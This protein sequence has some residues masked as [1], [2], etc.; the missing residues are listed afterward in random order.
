M[1]TYPS[2]NDYNRNLIGNKRKRVNAGVRHPPHLAKQVREPQ[3]IISHSTSTFI[4]LGGLP[5]CGKHAQK[6]IHQS[7]IHRTPLPGAADFLLFSSVLFLP[8]RS[9]P[10][11]RISSSFKGTCN[12]HPPSRLSFSLDFLILVHPHLYFC[13]PQQMCMIIVENVVQ[14]RRRNLEFMLSLLPL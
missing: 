3:K 12:K 2:L 8:S 5:F 10:S 13:C 14:D 1:G 9:F 6:R 11:L 4:L 7:L